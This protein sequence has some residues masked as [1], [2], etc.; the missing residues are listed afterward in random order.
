M[1]NIYCINCKYLKMRIDYFF[2]SHPQN[3][4]TKSNWL[5]KNFVISYDVEPSYLNMDNDC[6]WFVKKTS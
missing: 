6:K 2:C 1:K 3:T 5:G 4:I